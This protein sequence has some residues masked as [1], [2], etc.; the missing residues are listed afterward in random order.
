MC[1]AIFCVTSATSI[2]LPG[3]PSLASVRVRAGRMVR[4]WGYRNAE[5]LAARVEATGCQA[6]L[7]RPLVAD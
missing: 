7:R 5:G 6:E 3:A 1:G 2:D 4:M